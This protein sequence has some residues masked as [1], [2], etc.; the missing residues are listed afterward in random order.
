MRQVKK[1]RTATN[2]HMP[3]NVVVHND[4]VI[5]QMILPLHGLAAG[6]IGQPNR[7]VIVSIAHSI[8]PTEL[9]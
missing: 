2:T 3:G 6:R 9:G 5:V 7:S 4:A 8:A 1:D